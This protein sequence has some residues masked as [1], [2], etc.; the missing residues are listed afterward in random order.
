[1][2]DSVFGARQGGP[3]NANQHW[4]GRDDVT[5]LFFRDWD[6][7]LR[8]FSSSY[9]QQKVG[10]DGALFAD[11]ETNIV[12]M[13]HEKLVEISTAL[14]SQR[15]NLGLEERNA[16]VALYFISSPKHEIEGQQLEA[17]LTPLLIDALEQHCHEDVWRVV[18]NIGAKS[19]KFDLSSYFGGSAMPQYCLVYKISLRDRASVPIFRRSQHSF[20]ATAK[21]H[22]DLHTSFVLFGEDALIMDMSK[23]I[24]VCCDLLA[25]LQCVEKCS[26][27]PPIVSLSFQIY[28]GPLI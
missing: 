2:F 22:F 11:Y 19:D 27:S 28:L 5:E 16:I 8:C 4:H 24:R 13:A 23:D 10:P 20:E 25:A 26:S 14:A 9:V 21:A 18:A 12:L 1:M 6:H 15:I 3:I 17:T 7:V